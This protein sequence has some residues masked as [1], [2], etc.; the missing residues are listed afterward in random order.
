MSVAALCL[1]P[2]LSLLAQEPIHGWAISPQMINLSSGDSQRFQ[3]LDDHGQ[4]MQGVTWSVDEPDVAYV[5]AEE[6]RLVSEKAGT[7]QL[8]A[9]FGG[10]SK[11]IPVRIWEGQAPTNLP[12]SALPALG[13][14]TERIKTFKQ[15]SEGP[16]Q[17]MLDQT[18]SVTYV[19][20][21]TDDGIQTSVTAIPSTPHLLKFLCGDPSGGVIVIDRLPASYVLY[22]INGSGKLV[23]SYS[24]DA[25]EKSHA[26]AF[27]N[28]LFLVEQQDHTNTRVVGLDELSGREKFR[29]PLPKSREEYVGFT[30]SDH[31]MTCSP[32]VRQV[33]EPGIF[34]SNL[35]VNIDGRARFAFTQSSIILRAPSCKA[36]E[37]I[38]SGDVRAI[39]DDVLH[40]WKIDADGHYTEAEIEARH[41]DA[42][43]RTMAT[44]VPAPTGELIDD[45]SN[46]VLLSVQIR[47]RSTVPAL[48][49]KKCKEFIYHFT[50]DDKLDYKVALPEY[51][52]DGQSSDK[53][54]ISEFRESELAFVARGSIV[55]AFNIESGVERWRWDSGVNVR[56]GWVTKQGNVAVYLPDRIVEVQDPTHQKEI[57]LKA[58]RDNLLANSR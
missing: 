34:L 19:R 48:V 51:A 6:V 5:D 38:P 28:T 43:T 53:I 37:I 55:I 41:F 4:Q 20:A 11:S 9:T 32:G 40:L 21:F 36:G 30:V 35:F 33:R 56:I 45:G 42:I 18:D 47:L 1:V 8:T 26:L 10:Q 50:A 15:D 23:W 25:T 44:E 57:C 27:N 49:Q 46:G 29:L 2:A 3:V 54:G 12:R 14:L 22:G 58:C 17:F 52:Y 13:T 24:G 39:A 16:E 7:V 31:V